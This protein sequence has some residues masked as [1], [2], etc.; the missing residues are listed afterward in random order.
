MKARNQKEAWKA[1]DQIF[2]T[3]YIKDEAASDRAGYPI[4]KSTQEGNT[5][6]ISDLGDRLEVNQD[7]KT[8]NI[9]I[10]ED[11]E[12]RTESTV[13]IDFETETRKGDET[14][15]RKIYGSVT[16]GK[17]TTLSAVIDF[18]KT[19]EK[20][21]RAAVAAIAAGQ[22]FTLRIDRSE[23]KWTGDRI[24]TKNFDSWEAVP[25]WDQ[26]AEEKT[27]YFRPDT[28]YTPEH[29]DMLLR[30]GH[31]FEDMAQYIG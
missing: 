10:E 8:V 30:S 5:N 13:F 6:W 1:A 20:A 9:W 29:R 2:R 31:A 28:K 14:T 7:G 26:S 3:D 17:D 21:V 11:D 22:V 19:A 4:Y 24:E 23:Y 18:Q 27:V 25:V 15:K 12:V 16:F